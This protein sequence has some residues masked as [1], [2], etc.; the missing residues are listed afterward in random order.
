ML[1]AKQNQRNLP[2]VCVSLITTFSENALLVF[3]IL[4]AFFPSSCKIE[5]LK[6][7]SKSDL[8][9]W[10]KAH[11]GPGSKMLSVHVFGFF[12]VVGFGKYEL[13]EDGSP[14]GEDSNSSCEAMQ[15]TYLPSSPLLVD[16]TIPITDIRA[17][18]STLNLLPYHK[19]VK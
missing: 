17:F 8:V 13:E 5:A 4:L 15:L 7:F 11:R 14:S 19:I 12:Q 6:S 9:N 16:A 18:T 1:S 10:F 3:H 2:R